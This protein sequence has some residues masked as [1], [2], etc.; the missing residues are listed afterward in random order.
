MGRRFHGAD[1]APGKGGKNRTP[2]A[3]RA[4]EPPTPRDCPKCLGSGVVE[5]ETAA[6]DDEGESYT[7]YV[8]SDCPTCGGQG[9]I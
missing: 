8:D 6:T 4:N 7:E 2:P 9:K 3:W 1:S 5:T